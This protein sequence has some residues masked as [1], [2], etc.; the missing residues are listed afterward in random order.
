M[1]PEKASV[2]C[3]N[4]QQASPTP[5]TAPSTPPASPPSEW[6]PQYVSFA[7]FQSSTLIYIY[8]LQVATNALLERMGEPTALVVTKGFKDLLHIGNQSRPDI[9]DLE[10]KCPDVLYETVVEVDELVILPLD[11]DGDDDSM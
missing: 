5:A 9:F 6:A 11:G 7:P 3:W 8:E 10:I 2:A 4:N 1:H